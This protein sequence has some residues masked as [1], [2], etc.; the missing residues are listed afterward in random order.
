MGSETTL[1]TIR[2]S[3]T[4]L[5]K[6]Q[7]IYLETFGV[8]VSKQDAL[9]QGMALVRLVKVLATSPKNE[10]ENNNELKPADG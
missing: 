10:K 8:P 5:A 7:Q 2:I 9:V 6:Y 1:S 3:D 4:Q